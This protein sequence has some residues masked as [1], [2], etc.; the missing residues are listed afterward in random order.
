MKNFWKVKN[1]TQEPVKITVRVD[2]NAPGIIL[3]PNQF[4]IGAQQMTAPLDKQL[5]T[6]KITIEEFDNSFYD[7]TLAKAYDESFFDKA[8][9][10]TKKYIK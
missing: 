9:E 2:F 4:C 6:K 1:I 7:L 8:K 10:K 5:R 3:Q